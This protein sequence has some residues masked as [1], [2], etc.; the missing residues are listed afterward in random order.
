MVGASTQQQVTP[1]M[2]RRKA[3]I[4]GTALATL[5]ALA[6]AGLVLGTANEDDAPLTGNGL[7]RATQAALDHTG[8]GTVIET[9]VGDDRAAYGVEIRRHDGTVVEVQLDS[10]FRVIGEESDDD[11]GETEDGRADD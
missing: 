1:V 7:E 10:D 2:T 6:G 11:E 4:A 8:G 9:E 5:I 3:W